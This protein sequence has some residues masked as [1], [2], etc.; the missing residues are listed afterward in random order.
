MVHEKYLGT[1]CS[2]S[3]FLDGFFQGPSRLSESLSE[4]RSDVLSLLLPVPEQIP[5][6]VHPFQTEVVNF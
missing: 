2:N 3:S 1:F 5:K 4:L 6:T